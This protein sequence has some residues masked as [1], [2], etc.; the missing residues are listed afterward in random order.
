MS[1]WLRAATAASTLLLLG[2][3]ANPALAQ[4]CAA[5]QGAY[6]ACA[7][8]VQTRF[9]SGESLVRG[10]EDVKVEGLGVWVSDLEDVFAGSPE[11]QELAARFRK[12][13]NTGTV[14]ASMGLAAMLGAVPP[15]K[16]PAA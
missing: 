6:A 12:R 9:F 16:S 2:A 13:H 14:L 11:A 15:G 7:L 10:G 1:G 4:T 8:R 5:G 3:T